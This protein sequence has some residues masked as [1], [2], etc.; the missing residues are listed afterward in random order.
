MRLHQ[1]VFCPLVQGQREI[2]DFAAGQ[3]LDIAAVGY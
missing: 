3:M 2:A 1:V